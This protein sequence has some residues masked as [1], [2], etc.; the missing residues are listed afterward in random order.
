MSVSKKEKYKDLLTL[1]LVPHFSGRAIFSIKFRKW[2]LYSLAAAIA[3]ALLIFILSLFYSS[4]LTRKMINYSAI[5]AQN[6]VQQYQINS[7]RKRSGLLDN[8]IRELTERDQ[9]IRGMLGLGNFSEDP[10]AKKKISYD[11]HASLET[12]EALFAQL[13]QEFN[14]RSESYNALKDIVTEYQKHFAHTP[15]IWPVFG[16]VGSGFGW[17]RHP[18]FGNMSFHTG[19]DII[20]WAGSPV[21]ATADGDVEKAEWSGGYGQ[22]IV[23]DHL[24]GLKTAYAHL[25]RFLVRPGMKVKKGQVIAES[26]STGLSTGAHLHYEI[27]KGESQ[28]L[29]TPYLNMDLFTAAKK[30]Y[31]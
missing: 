7:L 15:S 3:A 8:K 9:Q 11:P 19:L 14:I 10:E 13:E 2:L 30:S 16:N 18:V 17:R 5:I 12:L 27:L 23:L 28:L 6:S 21:K 20:T 29:P 22:M 25:S 26:G 31:W 4:S 1:M 24:Y